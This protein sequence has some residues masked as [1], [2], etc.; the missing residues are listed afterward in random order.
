MS[1]MKR[2]PFSNNNG[3]GGN[4]EIPD[5]SLTQ[6]GVTQLSNDIDSDNQTLAATSKA[7]KDSILESKAHTEILISQMNYVYKGVSPPDDTN[8]IWLKE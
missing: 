2:N 5:A 1:L 3:G 7:V 6:K 4:V 8:F